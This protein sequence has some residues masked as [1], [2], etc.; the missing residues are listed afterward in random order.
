LPLAGQE[1]RDTGWDHEGV[2]M[3]PGYG[4]AWI[5]LGLCR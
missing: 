5:F 3:F 1:V 4:C 2:R